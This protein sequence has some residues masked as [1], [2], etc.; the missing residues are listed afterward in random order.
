MSMYDVERVEKPKYWGIRPAQRGRGKR[1]PFII[2]FDSEADDS[3]PFL[4]Q[5]SEQGTSEDECIVVDVPPVDNAGLHT[6]M[7]YICKRLLGKFGRTHEVIFYGWNLTY[8][9]TQLFHDLPELAD[10]DEVNIEM[11]VDYD[12]HEYEF[13]WTVY[14]DKRVF[15]KIVNEN[16]HLT[17]RILD[18][19]MFYKTGLDKGAKMLGLGEKYAP[20]PCDL[21]GSWHENQHDNNYITRELATDPEFLRYARRDAYI[22]RLIGEQIIG[23]HED[24]D[25]PQTISA[26]HFASSVF[27]RRFLTREIE[28]P[29][30]PLEQAG[31]WS[32]HGGKNGFYLPGPARIEGCW[33]Y[34]IT[35]AYPEAMRQL[36]N[37]ETAAW[38]TVNHYTPNRHAIYVATLQYTRCPWR[39]MMMHDGKWPESGYIEDVC[40]T[41]YEL[42]AMVERGEAKVLSCRGWEM[43]GEPGGPLEHYVDV[44]F[45]EKARSEGAKRETAKLM[46]NSLYG[47]F[48][49]KVALGIVGYYSMETHEII[50]HNPD[51]A[52]DWRASGLYHP[53]IASLITGFVRAKIH[54]MEHKYQSIMTSTDGMF[55]YE[56][57]D[58]ADVGRDLGA[59]TAEKGELSIWR[60]R[61]YVFRSPA[62][63]APKVAYHGFWGKLDQLEA[64]PLAHGQYDYT[65]RHM[66]TL[67]ESLHAFDRKYY[68]PGSFIVLP[69]SI[70]L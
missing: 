4:F 44:F 25:I 55:A 14:N 7:Q 42:D 30:T 36:P 9:W 3:R 57:P 58:P 35:S 49:Q 34:D 40:L 22:T 26:P 29:E 31:L 67:K 50:E 21:V 64:V 5:F 63:A 19:M 17:I 47:K 53:P 28:L 33:Q 8:E 61:L 45:T 23:L 68:E 51:G 54:R 6:F 59:L 16:A 48:F 37:I 52:F 69:R 11:T 43:E 60:E 12:G 1:I 20:A 41:S 2:G 66:V 46:L 32:Y 27:K 70:T 56:P 15:A 13:K 65:S 24:Y 38:R 62:L 10:Q 39:G 18:G